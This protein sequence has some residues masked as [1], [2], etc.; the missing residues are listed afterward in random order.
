M[1]DDEDDGA[2]WET[3][4]RR[5]GSKGDGSR[6]ALLP[7]PYVN[8][9]HAVT[10]EEKKR[11][12]FAKANHATLSRQGKAQMREEM[13]RDRAGSGYRLPTTTSPNSL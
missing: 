8:L 1:R 9:C 10:Q 11:E 3:R 2:V 4:S 7:L 13:S 5:K 6:F 12:K